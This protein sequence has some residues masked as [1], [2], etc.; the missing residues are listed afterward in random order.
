MIYCC[1]FHRYGYLEHL[2]EEM[3]QEIINLES[4]L[5]RQMRKMG[6]DLRDGLA[7]DTM[8]IA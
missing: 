5:F 2:E 4:A 7:R 1:R 8:V 6:W 3:D